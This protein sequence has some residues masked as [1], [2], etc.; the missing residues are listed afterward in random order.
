MLCSIFQKINPLF[1]NTYLACIK[2]V[3][4]KL[5][6]LS[7]RFLIKQLSSGTVTS[8]FLDVGSES[9]VVFFN[10]YLNS[11]VGISLSDS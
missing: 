11:S 8:K 10:E 3:T 4:P 5:P 6:L 2:S 7:I 1:F 9:S